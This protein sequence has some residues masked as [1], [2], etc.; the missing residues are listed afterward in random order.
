MT[1][2]AYSVAGMIRYR[3]GPVERDW[4]YLKYIRQFPCAVCG[5]YRS[6]ACHVG[7]H[8]IGQKA[9]DIQTIPL[10]SKHHRTGPDALHKLGPVKFQV[11]HRLDFTALVMLF[12]KFY[13][14]KQK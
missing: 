2:I 7:P 14:E 13:Q 12:Q 11:L 8:G 1:R 10:C 5:A 6:E 9:S 4:K 3:P